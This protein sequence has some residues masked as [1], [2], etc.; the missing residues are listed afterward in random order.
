MFSGAPETLI[1]GFLI[2]LSG[3]LAPGPT[4]VATIDAS[5]KTGWQAGPKITLGHMAV[6]LLVFIL[7]ILGL[8]AGAVRYSA[9]I[10]LFGGIVLIVFG[11]LTFLESGKREYTRRHPADAQGPYLSGIITS[12]TNPY[13]WI[14]W[15][16]IGSVLLISALSGGIFLAA[17]FMAGHWA[18][19]LGWYT[20][21]SSAIHRGRVILTGRIYRATLALCGL[22]LIGFGGYYLASAT[23]LLPGGF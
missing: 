18:A 22:F 16:T 23:D 11:I 5:L 9:P 3:A 2:G 8:S 19:D 12:A 14:W 1:I 10:A 4:L 15:L 21:V 20:F 13:F 6:E 17:V 7:I